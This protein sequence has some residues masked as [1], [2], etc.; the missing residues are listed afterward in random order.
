[1]M[2]HDQRQIKASCFKSTPNEVMLHINT[3]CSDIDIQKQTLR[4]I[5]V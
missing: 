1:M 3:Q 5:L 2:G 4:F